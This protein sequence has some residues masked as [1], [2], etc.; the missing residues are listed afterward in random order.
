MFPQ[1][2]CGAIS[3]IRST[4]LRGSASQFYFCH[5]AILFALLATSARPLIAQ[6]GS[7]VTVNA[8]NVLVLN[9][10]KVFPI[11]FSPGPPLNSKTPSGKD[12]LQ[13]LR[14]AGGLLY[15]MSQSTDWDSQT[16]SNQQAVLDW[17]YQHGM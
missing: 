8:D 10:R 17:A 15:R 9:G 11:G 14:D 2:D 4:R 3:S 7:V 1:P 16:V 5:A 13:E 6:T 12:A